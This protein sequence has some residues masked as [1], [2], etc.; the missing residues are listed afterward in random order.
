MTLPAR[1]LFLAALL[2]HLAPLLFLIAVL[3]ISALALVTAA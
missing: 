2:V 3:G 1:L